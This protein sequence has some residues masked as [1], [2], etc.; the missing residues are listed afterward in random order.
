MDTFF[1]IPMWIWAAVPSIST[2]IHF[3]KICLRSALN[4]TVYCL[5]QLAV[6]NGTTFLLKCAQKKGFSVF[7][8]EC[9]YIAITAQPRYGRN[10]RIHHHLRRLFWIKESILLL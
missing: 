9:K 3:H 6:I 4:P 7:V 2:E 8:Q 5:E 10:L 1:H